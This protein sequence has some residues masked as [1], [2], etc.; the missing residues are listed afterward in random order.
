VEIKTC[1]EVAYKII[2]MASFILIVAFCIYNFIFSVFETSNGILHGL[3]KINF[4]KGS[5]YLFGAAIGMI[6]LIWIMV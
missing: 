5:F 2:V 1:K 3:E 4:D 6:D